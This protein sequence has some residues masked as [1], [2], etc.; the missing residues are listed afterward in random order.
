[1]ETT[2]YSAIRKVEDIMGYVN[3]GIEEIADTQVGHVARNNPI[4]VTLI[5]LGVGMLLMNLY[6][7]D[8]ST[9][10]SR[11]RS[12]SSGSS[13]YGRT[14]YRAG[15]TG[16]VYDT[17]SDTASDAYGAVTDAASGAYDQVT[18][19]ANT[20]YRSVGNVA[21]KA[22]EQV[23]QLGSSVKDVAGKA[24]DQYDHY[25][26]ENPLAVGAVAMALGAAVGLSIPATTYESKLMGET[27]DKLMHQAG[28]QVGDLIRNA[29]E[30]A[31]DKIDKIKA[32][33]D[34]TINT[35]KDEAKNQ[36]LI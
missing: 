14:G 27:R 10:Y 1:W 36:D 31:Q 33:A 9:N 3:K 8:S 21:G 32:V 11:R 16:G 20:A 19:A 29:G 13:D 30:V 17:V 12:L 35:A 28:S 23:G 18:G 7:N 5:G 22:Y 26:E 6:R 34:E 2:K 4:A 24:Y 15:D 25:I